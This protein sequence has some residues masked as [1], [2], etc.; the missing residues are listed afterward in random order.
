[1]GSGRIATTVTM[2]ASA[3][4]GVK[5]KADSIGDEER[6]TS[7]ASRARTD[8]ASAPPATRRPKISNKASSAGPENA[9]RPPKSRQRPAPILA[10]MGFGSHEMGELGLGPKATEV[11]RPRLISSLDPD[12]KTTFHVVQLDCG[13]MHSLALTVDNKI[14]S[15]GVNDNGALGRETSWDGG[16]RDVDADESDDQS[17]EAY[18]LNPRESSPAEILSGHFTPKTRFV[19]VAA[20]DSCSFVVTDTGLVYGWG[21]FVNSRGD[22]S[23]GYTD[24]ETR[25]IIEIQPVPVLVPDLKDVRQMKCG[26]SHAIALDKRGGAWAWGVDEQ[27]QLGRAERSGFGRHRKDPLVPHRVEACPGGARYIASGPYHSFA[28]DTRGVVW[29]VSEPESSLFL[30][31]LFLSCPSISSCEHG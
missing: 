24:D 1:M 12:A 14:L 13:G 7:R 16:V 18:D 30:Y 9:P 26:A 4:R 27:K 28:V 22:K 5:R 29:S 25:K 2:V 31:H 19:Q 15:W 10:V 8:G 21:T 3:S 20:G 6:E 23:F 11:R 17:E